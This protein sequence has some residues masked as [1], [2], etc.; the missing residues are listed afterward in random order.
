MNVELGTINT[1]EL[2]TIKPLTCGMIHIEIAYMKKYQGQWDG[3]GE[4]GHD[5]DNISSVYYL[6][7]FYDILIGSVQVSCTYRKDVDKLEQRRTAS[8][9]KSNNC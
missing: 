3:W 8:R 1:A 4:V 6:T 2:I 9:V 5:L 7:S